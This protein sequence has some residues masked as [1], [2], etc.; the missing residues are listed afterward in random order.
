MRRPSWD[1]DLGLKAFFESG[2]DRAGTEAPWQYLGPLHSR[3]RERLLREHPRLVVP[4]E[5]ERRVL[6]LQRAI[7]EVDRPA[8]PASKLADV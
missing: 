2:H 1:Y 7:A 6:A 8:Q 5:R 3:L 4:T